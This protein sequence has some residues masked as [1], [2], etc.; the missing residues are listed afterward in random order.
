VRSYRRIVLE[1]APPD[2]AGLAYF[3]ALALAAFIFGYWWFARTRRNFADV[4]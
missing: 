3:T 1:G 2:F 4:I